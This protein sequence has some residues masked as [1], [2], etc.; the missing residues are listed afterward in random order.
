MNLFSRAFFAA[1]LAAEK[2]F[3]EDWQLNGRSWPSIRVEPLT[4]ETKLTLGTQFRDAHTRIEVRRMIFEQSGV[5]EGDLVTI[6]GETLRFEGIE[7]D[8]TDSVMMI[9]GPAALRM[10]RR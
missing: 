10:P 2:I 3:G 1:D 9:L 4:A 8:V 5:K 6:R 7:S